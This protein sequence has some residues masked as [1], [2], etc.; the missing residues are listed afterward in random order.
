[1]R[2]TGRGHHC[3]LLSQVSRPSLGAKDVQGRK[4]S[5]NIGLFHPSQAGVRVGINW[6][7]RCCLIYI[8]YQ[9]M[10]LSLSLS[11]L[12]K[13]GDIFCAVRHSL[14]I[15]NFFTKQVTKPRIGRLYSK[16]FSSHFCLFPVFFVLIFWN[17][18]MLFSYFFPVFIAGEYEYIII[19][20][21]RCPWP[22]F[23][24]FFSF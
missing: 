13:S 23:S 2:G 16:I 5:T 10:S 19:E 7:S 11:L 1:M 12:C 20:Q 9:I 21:F 24:W 6:H 15:W 18:I 14:K 4:S 3:P 22:L 17:F 8:L